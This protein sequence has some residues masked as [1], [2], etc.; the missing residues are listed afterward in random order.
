MITITS[1]SVTVTAWK[2]KASIYYNVCLYS[3][4]EQLD[5]AYCQASSISFKLQVIHAHFSDERDSNCSNL[6][7]W[8]VY[9]EDD[10]IIPKDSPLTFN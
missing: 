7:V 6:V 9:W 2:F 5:I 1:A 10:D 4:S 8:G 3:F